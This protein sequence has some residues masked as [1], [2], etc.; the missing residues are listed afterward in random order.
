[1]K[2]LQ[3]N[4]IILFE[5]DNFIL[6]NKPAFIATLDERDTTRLSILKLLSQKYD[7]I[8][9]AHRLDKE[10]SGVLAAAKNPEAYRHL[11]LQF[12]NREVSKVYHAVVDG[13]RSYADEHVTWPIAVS[14]RGNVRID[15]IDGKPSE[16]IFNTLKTFQKH[17]LVEC[18]PITGRMHQIRI[19][20]ASIEAPICADIMYGGVFTY[21]SQIKKKFKLKKGTEELPLIS[22]VALHAFSLTFT[23]MEGKEHTVDAAYPKDIRAFL[24]QLENNS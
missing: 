12:Q 13:I 6:I 2:P 1:M 4:D 22:R 5:D 8:Q 19:H 15:T 16:T 10:T 14:N 23:D 7:D 21:L 11:S 17:T 9:L 3:L 18:K 20:L 24:R